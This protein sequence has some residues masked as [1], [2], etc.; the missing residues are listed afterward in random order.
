MPIVQIL[1]NSLIRAVELGLLAIGLTMVYDLLKFANFSH[2]EFAILGAYLAFLFN[3]TLELNIFLSAIGAAILTG[4]IGISLDR[5]IFERLRGVGSVTLM[6][7]S[8]GLAIVMRNIVRAIWGADIKGYAIEL[9]RPV[10]F[11]GARM[12]P[13]QMWIIAIAALCMVAFHLLLHKTKL[14]KSMRATSDNPSL[15]E[16]SGIDTV[17]VIRW[18][19]FISTSFA[20]I[21]GILIGLE[22]Q[23][24]P[25]MGF[26]LLLPV[27]CATILGGIGNPYGAVV[28]ALA[29]GLVEN[30]GLYFNFGNIINLGG[31][32]DLVGEIYVP[33]SYKPVISF[34]ILIIILLIRPSGIMGRKRER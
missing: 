24:H 27:F 26:V 31:V 4:F 23:L 8:F 9:Q 1:A 16:A 14:G 34:A 5:A 20:A 30:F 2:T 22:T 11:L 17:K 25:Q 15:A 21:G 33:T 28:G 32:F 12:T 13:I 19:W 6:V 10:K 7:T 29:L 3:V 18:V